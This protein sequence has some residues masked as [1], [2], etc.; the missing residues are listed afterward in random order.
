MEETDAEQKAM[1]SGVCGGVRLPRPQTTELSDAVTASL[2]TPFLLRS[3]YFFLSQHSVASIIT[4]CREDRDA[5]KQP[6]NK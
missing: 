2:N 1:E 5:A 3:V 6:N 4:Q